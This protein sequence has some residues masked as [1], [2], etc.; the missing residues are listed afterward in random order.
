MGGSVHDDASGSQYV[1]VAWKYLRQETLQWRHNKHD[2]DSNHQPH[3][4]LL[5]CLFRRRSKKTSKLRVSGLCAGKSPGTGEFPV[6]M[7]S[8][9]ENI[10]IDDV[11]MNR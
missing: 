2:C 4:C 11:I 9:E 6:Q 5:N 3:Q 1:C 10:S 7:A 8:N